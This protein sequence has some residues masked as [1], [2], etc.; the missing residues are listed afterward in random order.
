[1]A[2]LDENAAAFEA[3]QKQQNGGV[4]PQDD[5]VVVGD[6][7]DD[8]ADKGEKTPPGFMS[9]DEYVKAGKDPDRY[10]GKKA[11]EDDYK[12]IQEIKG[13]KKEFKSFTQ[14][15]LA[16]SEQTLI[17]E[18]AEMRKD[19]EAELK[20]QKDEGDVEGALET[21][22]KL[23]E[24]KQEIKQGPPPLNPVIQEFIEENPIL[25]KD[26]EEFNQ[27]FFDD[28]ARLQAKEIN[29]LSDKG[30]ADLTSRQLK[31]CTENAFRKAQELN[32]ELFTPKSS[33]R[34]DRPGL[35]RKAANQGGDSRG[36]S[37]EVKL[38][39]MRIQDNRNPDMN[40]SPAYD[41]YKFIKEK[42]GDKGADK[43]AHSALKEE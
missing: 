9:Y 20:R 5:D 14:Q 42:Y 40:P 38:K 19:L 34:N 12:R 22:E 18:R 28:M 37:V 39:N 24:L 30:G 3:L 15:V 36:Q 25:D 4:E 27:E 21:K 1:M 33:P 31:K 29:S 10:K 6:P 11:Y 13:L 41:I 26:S 23:I 8:K 16:A 32:Q 35:G 7:P 43:F 2:K 17:K